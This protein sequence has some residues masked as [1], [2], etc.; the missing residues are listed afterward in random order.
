MFCHNTCRCKL[1]RN[2]K[3]EPVSYRGQMSQILGWLAL[4]NRKVNIAQLSVIHVL[5]SSVKGKILKYIFLP[6]SVSR[7]QREGFIETLQHYCS[8]SWYT[9]HFLLLYLIGWYKV[10]NYLDMFIVVALFLS[11]EWAIISC[12]VILHMCIDSK[13]QSSARKQCY[14]TVDRNAW[15]SSIYK[16]YGIAEVTYL[17]VIYY[18]F[19]NFTILWNFIKLVKESAFERV[20]SW[21]RLSRV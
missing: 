6:A 8:I 11:G 10:E 16:S 3:W 13:S 9:T 20:A 21:C 18:Y 2:S 5:L 15:I 14:L 7:T 1:D 4:W 19:L 12:Y 17:D